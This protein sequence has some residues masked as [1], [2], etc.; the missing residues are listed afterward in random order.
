[1]ATTEPMIKQKQ[2]ELLNDTPNH[3]LLGIEQQ[4]PQNLVSEIASNPKK[5]KIGANLIDI[6]FKYDESYLQMMNDGVPFKNSEDIIRCLLYRKTQNLAKQEINDVS[7]Y[8]EGIKFIVDI[9]NSAEFYS[10]NDNILSCVKVFP[11]IWY[12]EDDY[13]KPK[14]NSD[15]VSILS[16]DID[17]TQSISGDEQ[18]IYD[19]F[20]SKISQKKNITVLFIFNIRTDKLLYQADWEINRFLEN[21]FC[22]D[23]KLIFNNEAIKFMDIRTE[24]FVQEKIKLYYNTRMPNIFYMKYNGKIISKKSDS[25]KYKEPT[26]GQ[27][28]IISL[29]NGK[30]ICEGDETYLAEIPLTDDSGII[31]YYSANNTRLRDKIK[32]KLEDIGNSGKDNCCLILGRTDCIYHFNAD[33]IR[34]NSDHKKYHMTEI[35]ITFSEDSVYTEKSRK[36]LNTITNKK[37]YEPTNNPYFH[38]IIE[39]I[40]ENQ[41]NEAKDK[42]G[43]KYTDPDTIKCVVCKEDKEFKKFTKGEKEKDNSCGSTCKECKKTPTPPKKKKIIVK[44][45]PS[46]INDTPSPIPPPSPS[47][48]SHGSSS[49]QEVH[50]PVIQ[51]TEPTGLDYES[52]PSTTS[53]S[54]KQEVTEPATQPEEPNTSTGLNARKLDPP[55]VPFIIKL[56]QF[57]TVN[58]EQINTEEVQCFLKSLI[59]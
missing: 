55:P 34:N 40:R 3:K 57:I 33:K 9:S 8:D 22:D 23:T 17:I 13:P 35:H 51:S 39:S 10:L 46:P 15:R 32:T 44:K 28:R 48:T 24:Q 2:P 37:K 52:S 20:L 26:K 12:E 54:S 38:Q 43:T 42:W 47:T 29:N 19:D 1:M 14:G 58:M 21:K 41:Y 5:K 30:E 7:L 31:T 36:F 56:K 45:S 18:K 27:E 6:T 11:N 50:E 16:Y 25:S 59:K 4:L 53:P 49:I